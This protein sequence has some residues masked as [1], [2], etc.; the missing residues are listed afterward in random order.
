MLVLAARRLASM[1]LIMLVIS[2]MLFVFFEGDKLNLAM[3]VLG[4][5]STMEGRLQWLE[6]NG[7]NRP[8]DR[9]LFQL[10]WRLPHRRLE[11]IGAVQPPGLRVPA[12]AARQYGHPRRAA[13]S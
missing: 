9:A 10:A 3:R 2:V 13:C 12:A 8:L 6:E 11:G 4:P 7:Y 1:I 5:Y